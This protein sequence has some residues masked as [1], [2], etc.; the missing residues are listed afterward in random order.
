MPIVAKDACNSVNVTANSSSSIFPVPSSSNNSKASRGPNNVDGENPSVLP[1]TGST[2]NIAILN[3]VRSI[4]PPP[5]ESHRRK[6]LIAF[7]PEIEIPR[8]GSYTYKI[9]KIKGSDTY[10]YTK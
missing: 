8:S 3:S 7:A 9:K 5:S 4:S 2:A 6:I 1:D 10:H